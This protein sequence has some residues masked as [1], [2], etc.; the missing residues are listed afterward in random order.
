[1]NH[2]FD[3]PLSIELCHDSLRMVLILNLIYIMGIGIYVSMQKNY[4]RA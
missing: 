3:K 4:R 1:M 2:G